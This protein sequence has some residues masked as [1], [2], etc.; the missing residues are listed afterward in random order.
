WQLKLRKVQ[1]NTDN[2]DWYPDDINMGN[3]VSQVAED[4]L[5]FDG[6]YKFIAFDSRFTL[7]AIVTNSKSDNNKGKISN[8]P[9]DEDGT[10]LDAYI[11]WE[12]RF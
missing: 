4:V 6:Q 7:G 10:E 3:S 2:S 12:Y 9:N 5:Q 11:K 1:L 8:N